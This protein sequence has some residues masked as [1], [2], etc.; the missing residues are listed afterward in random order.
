MICIILV[1]ITG[2]GLKIPSLTSSNDNVVQTS[3]PGAAANPIE[4]IT[5]QTS[6]N[7]YP[8]P[9]GDS[10][11]AENSSATGN[12]ITQLPI[13]AP[14]NGKAVVFG[15]V[16]LNAD[17]G[18]QNISNLFLYPITSADASDELSSVTF[19]E[20]S[21]PI[22][23]LDIGSGQFVFV[24]VNPGQYAL[25]IWTSMRAYPIGDNLGKSIIFSV[26]PDETKD[27]GIISIH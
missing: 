15:E 2:C 17:T 12:P 19:S 20:G 1:I 9:L 24:D 26:N 27:L 21:D 14:S 13:P 11:N 22:A 4:Q 10:G 25:M 5:Q 23:T 7:A 18:G 16:K 8:E 6:F 3:T